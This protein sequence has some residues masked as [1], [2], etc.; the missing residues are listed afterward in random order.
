MFVVYPQ[1]W[2]SLRCICELGEDTDHLIILLLSYDHYIYLHD[3]RLIIYPK[4][5]IL[6][7]QTW[8]GL[9]REEIRSFSEQKGRG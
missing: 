7:P 5:I 3:H 9:E 1:T 6:S 2:W 8:R 4:T